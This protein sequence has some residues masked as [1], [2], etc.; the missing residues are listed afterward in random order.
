MLLRRL[1]NVVSSLA[2]RTNAAH[3][4]RTIY[5]I[6]FWYE[7]SYWEPTVQLAL[8]DLCRPGDIAFD[9]GANAGALTVLM[10]RL[11]GPR[12][13]VCAFEASPRIVDKTQYNVSRNGCGNVQIFHHAVSSASGDVVEIFAGSHLNDSILASNGAA[14]GVHVDTIALDDFV[15]DWGLAPAVV[16]MDIEGAELLALQGFTHTID[17]HHPHLILEQQPEDMRCLEMLVAMGYKAIDLANYLEVKSTGDFR[18]G[19]AVANVLF[20]HRDSHEHKY[21]APIKRQLVKSLDTQQL[22]NI[23]LRPGRYIIE[24]DMAAEG[25]NNEMM[26]GILENSRQIFR[27]HTHTSFLASSYRDWPL[28]TKRETTINLFFYFLSDTAD[29]TFCVNG[30]KVWRLDGF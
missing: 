23:T 14:T 25:S 11:V 22:S 13:T 2:G 3:D 21:L 29:P 30:V 4:S 24:V 6:P 1:R 10:S 20:I 9:V 8:K 15:A 12:G 19:T 16:K 5:P 7:T 27:Y 17:A 26:A 28:H 18:P